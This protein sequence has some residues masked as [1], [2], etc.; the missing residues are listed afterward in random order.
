MP[1]NDPRRVGEGEAQRRT[2]L[3][4]ISFTPPLGWRCVSSN[5]SVLGRAEMPLGVFT[6]SPPEPGC[7]L[8]RRDLPSPR[9]VCRAIAFTPL[10]SPTCGVERKVKQPCFSPPRRPS[11]T[12][13]SDRAVL[14]SRFR[15]RLPVSGLLC[16]AL[17][18][19]TS[20]RGHRDLQ[21]E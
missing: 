6:R 16:A 1:M 14:L 13:T 4:L 19:G 17:V 20:L 21:Q 8:Q 3:A 12:R 9:G 2:V 11:P 7:S 15:R 18:E 5:G 10:V